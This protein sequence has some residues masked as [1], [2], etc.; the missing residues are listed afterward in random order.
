MLP[1]VPL[2][3]TFVIQICSIYYQYAVLWIWN[4]QFCYCYV[5]G[6]FSPFRTHCSHI[7]QGHFLAQ[8]YL[9]HAWYAFGKTECNVHRTGDDVKM[10]LSTSKYQPVLHIVEQSLVAA[11]TDIACNIW[12]ILGTER[13]KH[14]AHY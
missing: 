1:F 12:K 5:L 9:Q 13:T 8:K 10:Y 6:T 7:K 11:W 14:F 2:Y 4:N 3:S